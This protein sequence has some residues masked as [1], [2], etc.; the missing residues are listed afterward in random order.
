MCSILLSPEMEIKS[1]EDRVWLPIIQ[2]TTQGW[3]E[4]FAILQ[5]YSLPVTVFF[6]NDSILCQ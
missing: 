1:S 2:C 4:F 6:A 5:R 3:G